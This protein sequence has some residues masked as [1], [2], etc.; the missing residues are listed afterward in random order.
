VERSKAERDER[1]LG[2]SA[3]KVQKAYIESGFGIQG[4]LDASLDATI[5]PSDLP[6]YS[7]SNFLS[8]VGDKAWMDFP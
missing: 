8:F 4:L 2:F 7:E 6:A 5:L 1:R 3:T